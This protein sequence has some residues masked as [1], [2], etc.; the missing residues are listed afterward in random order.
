MPVI[1][2]TYGGHIVDGDV[3]DELKPAIARW[4]VICL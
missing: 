1:E 3:A 4:A 2:P